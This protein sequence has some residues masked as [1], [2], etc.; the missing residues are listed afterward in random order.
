MKKMMED[1]STMHTT[2]SHKKFLEIKGEFGVQGKK[3]YA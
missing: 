1:M 2:D 3:M